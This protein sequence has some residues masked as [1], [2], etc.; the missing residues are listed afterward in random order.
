MRDC[1]CVSVRET[2]REKEGVCVSGG[3]GV[4]IEGE[5][6]RERHRCKQTVS[7]IESV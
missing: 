1:V 4:E 7:E 3:E 5:R 2:V 6:E